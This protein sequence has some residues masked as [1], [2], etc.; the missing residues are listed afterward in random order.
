MGGKENRI[1]GARLSLS[2]KADLFGL[3]CGSTMATILDYRALSGLDLETYR[4]IVIAYSGGVDS[5]V[6]LH[7]CVSQPS[8]KGKLLAVYINHGLQAEAADWGE[9]CRRQCLQWG[10]DFQIIKVDASAQVGESPEDAARRA[11]YS[12]LTALLTDNDALLLAQHRED[13]LETLLL[14]LFRGAGVAGL[15]GMPV[16]MAMGKGVALRP[17][18]GV[19]KQAILDYARHWQLEWVEDPSNQCSDYDRNFL[20]QEIVPLLKQRWPALDKTVARSASHCADAAGLI[21]AWADQAIASIFNPQ[22]GSLSIA[23]LQPLT[24]V[25]RNAVLR[26]WLVGLGLRPPSQAVLQ[27][28]VDQLIGA[29]QD[30]EPCVIHQGWHI[31]KFRQHLFCVAAAH[32][33]PLEPIKPW[34]HHDSLSL[35]NSS[36]LTKS[37]ASQGVLQSIWQAAEVTVRARQGG[38]KLKLPGRAGRHE[39]KKLYQ[40]AA[41]P[42]W[43]RDAR[44]LIYLDGRLAAVAGL[45]IDEWAW[46]SK[47]NG[48]YQLSWQYLTVVDD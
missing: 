47:E 42:P 14:Q 5:Q 44:P 26:R 19:A 3:F 2:N 25:Q 13:Q 10:L 11:R 6:L 35:A 37:L 39:L 34:H 43:E 36:Y 27:T 28:I 16:S 17:L 30:A 18:L 45:W 40:A 23:A 33:K 12:A 24:A 7:L 4:K 38:E 29:R 22:Q 46:A 31:R 15:A 32:L 8:L 20:R 41:I 48:C 9:H 21:D 1:D